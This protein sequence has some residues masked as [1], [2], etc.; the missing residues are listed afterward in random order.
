MPR[1]SRLALVAFFAAVAVIAAGPG[2]AT[3]AAPV[4]K[5]LMPKEEP[6]FYPTHVGDRHE[7]TIGMRTLVVVVTKVEKTDD[8]LLV[9]TEEED[10]GQERSVCCNRTK[11][12]GQPNR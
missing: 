9:T 1:L 12:F 3:L 4:P 7:S 11:R 5:H 2:D 6:F 8:G 10:N